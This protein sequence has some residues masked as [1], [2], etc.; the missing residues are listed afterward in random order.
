MHSNFSASW[1]ILALGYEH[2]LIHNSAKRAIKCTD[3][4]IAFSR[5]WLTPESS[6]VC[7]FYFVLFFNSSRRNKWWFSFTES[8]RTLFLTFSF[9]SCWWKVETHSFESLLRTR[10][11]GH[12]INFL[13]Q[14]QCYWSHF[15]DMT[16]LA[17]WDPRPLFSKWQK[18]KQTKSLPSLCKTSSPPC[19]SIQY[20]NL[21]S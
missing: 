5:K 7:L 16:A 20:F 11:G 21:T 9:Y 2:I 1:D 18:E 4:Q 17:C 13:R 12:H 14:A 6:L 15:M 19:Q 8:L 10:M 3:F